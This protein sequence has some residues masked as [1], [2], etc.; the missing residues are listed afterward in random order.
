MHAYPRDVDSESQRVV[1]QINTAL[2]NQI[3][4]K[5]SRNILKS[6]NSS[7][8]KFYLLTFSWPAPLEVFFFFFSPSLLLLCKSKDLLCEQLPA[9]ITILWQHSH[10]TSTYICS[11]Y[12][13]ERDNT[14]YET[15][16]I[17]QLCLDS[18]QNNKMCNWVYLSSFFF[19]FLLSFL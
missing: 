1:I 15:L 17:G 19:F 3:V 14:L 12:F 18:L 4:L 16:N 9:L 2:R 10:S 11:V 8:L 6:I 5:Q 7:H 13:Q